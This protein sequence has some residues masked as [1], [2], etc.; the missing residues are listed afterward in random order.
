MIT[1]PD[2]RFRT[3]DNRPGL[4]VAF[5]PMGRHLVAGPGAEGGDELALVD[6]AVLQCEQSEEEMAVG[7]DG[8]HGASLPGAGHGRCAVGPRRRGPAAVVRWIGWIIS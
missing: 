7:G 1:S 2:S 6:Q 8:G 4:S 5:I 3:A